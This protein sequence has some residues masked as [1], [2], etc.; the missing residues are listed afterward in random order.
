MFRHSR[1]G[2]ALAALSVL[3]MI[4]TAFFAI[5]ARAS[6][7]AT[8]SISDGSASEANSAISFTVSIDAPQS[9]SVSA[10]YVTVP[11]TAFPGL[12]FEMDVRS[13]HIPA[14]QTSAKL[15]FDLTDDDLAEG[16]E[17]LGAELVWVN[18]ANEGRDLAVGTIIDD[19]AP[20]PAPEPEPEAGPLTINVLHMNDHHSHLS[21]DGS[22]ADLGTSG[23]EF[24]FELGGFPQVVNA[25]NELSGD[26]DNVVKIHAGDA[27]T[28]TLFYSLFQG[29]ADAALMN[30]VCFDAF[31]LGNHEFDDSD[32]GL[33]DFLTDLAAGDCNTPVLA[34]NVVPEVGT[35]LAPNSPT[36]F[37]Q[38]YVIK[39]F[40]GQQVGF[41]GID[42]AQKTQVSSSPLETTQFLD[43]VETAQR[44]TDEL[45]AQGVDNVVLVTHFQYAN[46]L[47]LAS[48]VSGIDAIIGGDSHSL[49][50]DFG[51]FDLDSAGEYPTRTVNADGD[52]VCVVQAWQF[53]AVVGE[54]NLTF[55]D[56]KNVGCEGTPHL[57]VSN[58]TRE[59]EVDGD[60]I[61]APIAEPELS[62][63][64]AVIDGLPSVDLA[65]PDANA[66][67][68]LDGFSAQVDELSQQVIGEAT[69][70]LCLR[71]VPDQPRAG[72]CPDGTT[73]A[74]GADMN[75]NGGFI[76]QIVTDAFLERAFRADIAIQNAGGVRVDLPEG[77]VTIADAFTLLPFAN[78]LVEL[79]LSGAEVAAVLEEAVANFA[80][81]EGSTGSYP[82]GSA[83]RWDIDMG[84]AA[85]ERFSNIEIRGEDGTWSAIDPAANYVVVTNSFI[86]SGRDGY[87]TFGTAF[88]DGRVVD[89]F[90]DYAQGFIDW[91]EEDAGGQISV[92]DPE[93][94]S[95]QSFTPAPAAG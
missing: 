61:D 90:I 8:L 39:E 24:D 34:A 25:F 15:W 60:E 54:F 67:A 74:S 71:R 5:P 50:G 80:D 91:V 72:I 92:P 46:D 89:T 95:T 69:E 83:I 48:Q 32:A 63:I 31:A 49:L 52:P 4:S 30:E 79:E 3:A 65:V 62:E 23:G 11:Q 17:T 2:R 45:A 88:D 27:I 43:E 53:A 7:Q 82:Y 77:D 38:P 42:I 29:E 21:P 93:N 36:D 94:F 28:G 16:D 76:Q 37:I 33:A 13:I 57:L 56:G 78:T 10:W 19:D 64:L 59:V 35:P 55:E 26:L 1:K 6:D 12:D 70:D 51:P 73:S 20:A 87:L 85:G 41:I 14:G 86:A 58:F 47:A 22:S 84:M 9:H 18:G 75:A 44:F 40:D 81:D 68:I 66:Q